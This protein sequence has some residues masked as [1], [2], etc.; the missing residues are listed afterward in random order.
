VPLT[1]RNPASTF[2]LLPRVPFY[3]GWVHVVLAAIAMSAT[4]PGRT[5]GLALIKE[6]ARAS[7]GIGDFQFDLLNGWAIVLGAALALPVGW[8]IDRIG[9][10]AVL[11]GV[12]AALG[13]SV[14]LMSRAW[15]A[16]SLLVT[17]T[18]VRGLGQGALSVVAILLVGKW[19][20]RRI[21]P[22]MGVFSVLLVFGFVSTIPAV[23]TMVRE[24]GWR[25][26]W[27]WLGA[28]LAFGLAP[29]AW[30]LARNSPEACG[31]RPDDA[32]P[33]ETSS[34]LSLRLRQALRTPAFWVWSL[35]G[36]LFNFVFSALT[37]DNQSLLREHG[38]DADKINQT[39]LIVLMVSG[40]PANILA[41]WLARRRPVGKLLA[42]GMAILAVSLFIFPVVRSKEMAIGYAALLGAS[43]GIITVVWFALYG[44]TYGRP[45]L[46]G[47]QGVAQILSVLAS[48]AG[49]VA[50]SGSREYLGGSGWYFYLFGG[51]SVIFAILSWR[52]RPPVL[53]KSSEND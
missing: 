23:D 31:V 1:N 7:L 41:G 9:V 52:V 21:G 30:L 33:Q 17:L 8:L 47:I 48:A 29:L 22:A 6:P 49:P 28:S 11:T 24:F 50:L 15:D 44:H 16:T 51:A 39:V 13:A 12:A 43:G 18:L 37:L 19:F 27:G 35:A 53:A 26:A 36:C 40:L 42:V 20:K 5:Y 38:L 46:G 3:Y 34:A 25:E 4:L 32:G 45:H 10:R 14:L 2:S